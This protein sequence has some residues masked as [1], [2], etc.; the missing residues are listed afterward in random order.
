MRWKGQNNLIRILRKDTKFHWCGH[1]MW[2]ST[3]PRKLKEEKTQFWF[4][5][6]KH[7]AHLV[8]HF[9]CKKMTWREDFWVMQ[10]GSFGIGSFGSEYWKQRNLEQKQS[11]GPRR[12]TIVGIMCKLISI[13]ILCGKGS[14]AG[15]VGWFNCKHQVTMD[16]PGLDSSWD[17]HG[18]QRGSVSLPPKLN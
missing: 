5:G 9:V 12:I 2:F 15:Q 18:G 10:N 16:M 7:S 3:I 1:V 13:S 8:T 14:T 17:S 6:F 4:I 11:H